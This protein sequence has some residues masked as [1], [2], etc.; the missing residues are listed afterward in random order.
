M[1]GPVRRGVSP[2]LLLE[3]TRN[4]ASWALDPG[5]EQLGSSA[6][7]RLLSAPELETR[8]RGEEA[9]LDY[10]GIMLAA[11]YTT[12]ATFVPTDVDTHIRFHIWQEI[13]TEEALDR[14][15]EI[16]EEAAAWDVR[17]VSRRVVELPGFASSAG[18]PPRIYGHAGEWFS[19]RAGA[20]GRPE[21]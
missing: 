15:I 10:L 14:S 18:L 13:E 11:H 1:R 3:Q 8:W 9:H 5:P 19:V 4:T 16:L 6:R 2:S 12:V 21:H 7:A 17:A 20:L